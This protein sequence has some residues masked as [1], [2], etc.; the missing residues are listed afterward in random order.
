MT[1]LKDIPTDYR[2]GYLDALDGRTAVAQE[3]RRRFDEVASDLGGA[4]QLS[5]MQ[6]SLIA[7]FLW[8]E[9]WLQQQEIAIA[10][11]EA[12]DIGKYVQASNNLVG[13]SNRLG[14]DRKAKDIPSLN[15][16]IASRGQA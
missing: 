8:A 14:L 12:V 10:Q 9:H 4:E 7:R 6:R 15:D 2:P 16:Y 11:G 5:Y 1:K 3:M 13:L